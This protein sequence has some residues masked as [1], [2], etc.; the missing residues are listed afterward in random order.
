MP[1]AHDI[2]CEYPLVFRCGHIRS[3]DQSVSQSHNQSINQSWRPYIVEL[4]QDWSV[5]TVKQSASLCRTDQMMRFGLDLLKSHDLR[6]WRS[7]VM[8]WADVVFSG[9]AFQLRALATKKA[10]LMGESLTEG[11]KNDW[12][13]QNT[14]SVDVIDWQL[15]S[16]V[17]GIP[18]YHGTFPHNTLYVSTAVL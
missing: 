14:V 4:L 11:T 3:I 6:R 12:C 5:K 7:D 15:E 2:F 18:R 1:G 10:R 16:V 13:R 9:R 8:E 17:Q